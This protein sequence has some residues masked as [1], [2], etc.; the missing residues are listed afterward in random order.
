[1]IEGP[2]HNP[3]TNT[4]RRLI[5]ELAAHYGMTCG[6]SRGASSTDEG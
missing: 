2:R 3:V 4:R 1:V 6:G 5:V